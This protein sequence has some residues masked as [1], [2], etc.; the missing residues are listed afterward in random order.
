LVHQ[1]WQSRDSEPFREP[2]DLLLHKDYT[3]SIDT[4]MDLGTVREQLEAGNYDSP[5]E[6]AKDVKLIFTNSKNFNTNKKS[7]VSIQIEKISLLIDNLVTDIC[8]D[9]TTVEFV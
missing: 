1:L 4:P 7:K 9:R 8:H 2:V 5:I 3:K 6:F